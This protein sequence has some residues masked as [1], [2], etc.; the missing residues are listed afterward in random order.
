MEIV[1]N[2]VGMTYKIKKGLFKTYNVLALENFNYI[3][4]QGDIIGLLGQEGSGKST[5]IKILSGNILPSEGNILIDGEENYK[6]LKCNS[7]IISDLTSKKL[8]SNESVYNNLFSLGIKYQNDPLNVEKSIS[9]YK[10]IFEIDKFINRKINQLNKLELIKVNIIISMLKGVSILFFD[11]ALCDL[12]VVERNVILKLLKRLNKEYKTT[13]V[14]SSGNLDDIEKICKKIIVLNK[15]K[16]VKKGN[17]EDMK[18]ELCTNKEIKIIFNKSVIPPKGNFEIVEI[19]D[20]MIK[21]KVDFRKCDFASL[22]NAFDIN[23][24][25]DISISNCS[26]YDY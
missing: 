10:E 3:I 25:A 20:Y 16:I 17:F 7:I 21:I 11:S 13:I 5:L 22:I 6:K 9:I 24:I 2:N 4:K 8:I 14:V 19:A 1:S 15:G 12:K 18:T 26:I 23:T